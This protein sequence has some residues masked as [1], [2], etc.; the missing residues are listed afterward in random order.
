MSELY[1][2]NLDMSDV[3][4][5]AEASATTTVNLSDETVKESET[6]GLEN[7][8]SIENL[9]ETVLGCSNVNKDVDSTPT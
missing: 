4:P 2:E 8:K 5:I 7:P 3:K 1:N 6:L 9:G